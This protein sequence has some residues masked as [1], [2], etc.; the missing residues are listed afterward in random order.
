M[1]GV[2]EGGAWPEET[3]AL[4]WEPWFCS[5]LILWVTSNSSG[6]L[7]L[8]EGSYST[9]NGVRLDQQVKKRL[10]GAGLAKASL[11]N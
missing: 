11:P 9:T 7:A 10:G 4:I 1:E 2:A 3:F 5:S 8:G 6:T